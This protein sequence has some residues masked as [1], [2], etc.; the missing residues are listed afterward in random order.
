MAKATP[1][2]CPL[3]IESGEWTPKINLTCMGS[4]WY[5]SIACPEE[6][7]HTPG[8]Q[9]LVSIALNSLS[10]PEVAIE[11]RS[12][13][14]PHIAGYRRALQELSDGK[15]LTAFTGPDHLGRT[16]KNSNE[17]W[18]LVRLFED[19]RLR[20]Q[21][22]QESADVDR[23]SDDTI[24]SWVSKSTG[25]DPLV[26]QGMLDDYRL[27]LMVRND[28]A[29]RERFG[30]CALGHLNAVKS[31]C[32][33]YRAEVARMEEIKEIKARRSIVGVNT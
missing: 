14:E 28:P 10:H 9:G 18:E 29:L 15:A 16:L 30:D 2:V 24:I 19:R 26:L 32:E 8:I 5:A 12:R 13:M 1:V 11:A 4:R 6:L 20:E 33:Q 17:A 22:S 7:K 3:N 21:R 27:A 31:W 25:C 23:T